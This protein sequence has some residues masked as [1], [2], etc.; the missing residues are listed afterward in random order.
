[1]DS[2]DRIAGYATAYRR[3][4][5]ETIFPYWLAVSRGMVAL[6]AERGHRRVPQKSSV[7]KVAFHEVRALVQLVD[8][9]NPTP[10]ER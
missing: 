5:R 4:L 8:A 1:V 6:G 2:H 3:R 7:W 9:F 10:Q